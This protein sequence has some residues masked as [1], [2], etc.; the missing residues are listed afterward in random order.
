MS[1][2][3]PSPFLKRRKINPVQFHMMR[4]QNPELMD[5]LWGINPDARTE[6]D[7]YY[8]FNSLSDEH[9]QVMYEQSEDMR[10]R[11]LEQ[12]QRMKEIQLQDPEMYMRMKMIE[13][14]DVPS[15]HPYSDAE[16][17]YRQSQPL[18]PQE[19]QEE[20]TGFVGKVKGWWSD[21][22]RK[23]KLRRMQEEQEQAELEEEMRRERGG[24][25]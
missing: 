4:I 10:L 20:R 7:L 19:E 5:L 22:K 6:T 16:Q 13:K 2:V 21:R 17:D 25:R 24:R 23:K 15:E 12:E 11:R 3:Q 8:T 18:E 14:G 1:R 9:K